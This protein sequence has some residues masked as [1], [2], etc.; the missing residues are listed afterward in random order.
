MDIFYSSLT[1]CN[2]SLCGCE[3]RAH[4]LEHF[5]LN[6]DSLN[7]LYP[8]QLGKDTSGLPVCCRLCSVEAAAE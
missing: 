7:K 8:G 5:S 6:R 1:L 4:W 2:T 3:A